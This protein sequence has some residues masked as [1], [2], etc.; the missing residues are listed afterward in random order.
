MSGKLKTKGAELESPNQ[1]EGFVNAVLRPGNHKL[2]IHSISLKKDKFSEHLQMFVEGEPIA[3]PNFK[4][5]LINKDEKE[6]PRYKGQVG[7]LKY[8]RYGFKDDTTPQGHQVFRDDE[9]FRAIGLLCRGLGLQ[10][11][12]DGVDGKYDTVDQLLEAF[13]K[14]APYKGVWFHACVA[15]REYLNGTHLNYELYMPKPDRSLGLPYSLHPEKVIKY[16]ESVHVERLK[17]GTKPS[18]DQSHMVET[19]SEAKTV[20][21]PVRTKPSSQAEADFMNAGK[22]TTKE[23]RDREF[24]QSLEMEEPTSDSGAQDIVTNTDTDEGLPW[25]K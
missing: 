8:S 24:L 14:E 21:E 25:E 1:N 16:F 12:W 22:S 4:G 20:S 18:N 9:L 5:L 10:A 7:Y 6:G 2:T 17:A 23:E 15:G 3:T 19:K 11:W 13:V